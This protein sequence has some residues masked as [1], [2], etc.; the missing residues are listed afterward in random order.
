MPKYKATIEYLGTK[1]H[2]IQ[3][4]NDQVTIAGKIEEAIYKF[5]GEK[6]KLVISGRTD[7]G[8]HARGQVIDFKLSK[9]ISLYKIRE[10]INFYLKKEDIVILKIENVAEEF[11]SR[12]SAIEREYEY[13]ILNSSS[14]SAILKNRI[15]HVRKKL[16]L[17]LMKEASSYFRGKHDFSAFRNIQCQAKSPIKEIKELKIIKSKQIIKVKIRSSSFLHNQVRIMVGTMVEVAKGKYQ[18]EKIKQMLKSKKRE[19]AGMTA[20]ACGLYLTKIKF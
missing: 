20:P 13:L 2:G 6:V 18:P 12:F 11:N 17:K 4:Q 19:D 8:V 5:S 7:A 3:R 16:D 10:A 15:W 1:Y 14:P 9:K